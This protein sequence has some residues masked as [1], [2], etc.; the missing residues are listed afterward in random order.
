MMMMKIVMMMMMIM[1]IMIMKRRMKWRRSFLTYCVFLGLVTHIARQSH[2]LGQS[3]HTVLQL[4]QQ[5]HN[6][7][8][9][10][11]HKNW[12][13]F[14]CQ[15]RSTHGLDHISPVLG[16]PRDRV[17]LPAVVD[18]HLASQILQCHHWKMSQF[19]LDILR[20][21]TWLLGL[22]EGMWCS[23]LS[24]SNNHPTNHGHNIIIIFFSQA[25]FVIMI[26]VMI[27][28]L[29]MMTMILLTMMMMILILTTSLKTMMSRMKPEEPDKFPAGR[30][31]LLSPEVLHAPEPDHGHH[32]HDHRSDH[33]NNSY[34]HNS[35]Y[36]HEHD[37]TCWTPCWDC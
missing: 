28:I 1:M 37:P 29:I 6:S 18:C 35:T 3:I 14:K 7:R 19:Y 34:H 16:E 2:H 32:H 33:D 25:T 17:H 31:F 30:L 5:I 4:D 15:K 12:E 13:H 24:L 23:V 21:E 10:D 26:M 11:F 22:P 27:L 20:G 8:L 9:V 36:H